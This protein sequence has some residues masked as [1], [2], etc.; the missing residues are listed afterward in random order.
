VTKY[1][2]VTLRGQPLGTL[3]VHRQRNTMPVASG[4]LDRELR[5]RAV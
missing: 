3:R 2:Q 5:I 4:R 1:R